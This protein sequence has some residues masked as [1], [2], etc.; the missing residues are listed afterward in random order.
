VTTPLHHRCR[1]A[2][3][4]WLQSVLVVSSS[5]SVTSCFDFALDCLAETEREVD[6]D[7]ATSITN[8]VAHELNL[9]AGGGVYRH[10]GK[11]RHGWH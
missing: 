9:V 5:P 8:E 6:Y 7:E 3:L 11:R 10:S 1:L 4:L 2:V